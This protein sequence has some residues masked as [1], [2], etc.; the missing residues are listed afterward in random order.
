MTDLARSEM[1]AASGQSYAEK[2]Q[3]RTVNNKIL[4]ADPQK[5]LLRR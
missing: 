2:K 5:Y 3:L 4:P 1:R